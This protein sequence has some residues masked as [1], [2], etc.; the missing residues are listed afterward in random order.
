MT[1]PKQFR[2]EELQVGT[3]QIQHLMGLTNHWAHHLD[4]NLSHTIT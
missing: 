2:I 3:A 4:L 1:I